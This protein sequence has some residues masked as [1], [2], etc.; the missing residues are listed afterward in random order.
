MWPR[1]LPSPTPEHK[2]YPSDAR[3]DNWDNYLVPPRPARLRI[4]A[5]LW[6]IGLV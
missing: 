4:T 6:M 5:A 2:E 1:I 3:P